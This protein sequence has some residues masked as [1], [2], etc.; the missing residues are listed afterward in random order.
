[1]L[2]ARKEAI[3][4]KVERRTT[5]EGIMNSTAEGSSINHDQ[6]DILDEYKINGDAHDHES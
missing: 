4:K 6:E 5:R 3:R 2:H 1:M